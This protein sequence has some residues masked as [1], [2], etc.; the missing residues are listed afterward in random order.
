MGSSGPA[1]SAGPSA[2]AHSQPARTTTV[3]RGRARRY[4]S[5]RASPRL[6]RP[7][8]WAPVTGCGST[9]AL[10]TD[11]WMVPSGRNVDTTTRP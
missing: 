11:D 9:P 5:L 10:T 3:A 7:T 1:S 4:S 6:T 8:T 2:E